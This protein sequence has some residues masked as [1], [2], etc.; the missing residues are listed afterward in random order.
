MSARSL[1]VRGIEAATRLRGGAGRL[2]VLTYHRVLPAPD[3]MYP[4]APDA[5]AFRRAMETL[6]EDFRVLPLAEA[7]RLQAAG[8]LPARAVAVTFDDGF[9]DNAT[10]A[11][12]V[13][14]AF[15][16][17]ATFFIATGYL[18]DGYMFNNAV[19]EACRA[20]PEGTWAT[21]TAEFGDVA[22][23]P[24]P[25]RP[26]LAARMIGRLK[27]EDAGR[28]RDCAEQLLAS[29]GARQPRGL[30]MSREQVRAIAAAGMD[31][32]GHTVTHPIL[33]R[34]PDA[35]A[36]REIREGKAAL[37]ELTGA[38]V[39]LFAYPNGQPDGDY[40]ARDVALVRAA[41]FAAAVTTAWGCAD[42][43]SDRFQVPRIGAWGRDAWRFS[44]RL[45]AARAGARGRSCEPAAAGG[46]A[47]RA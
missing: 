16:V 46:G 27:Y 6:A 44:V 8:R 21:G 3:P 15:G 12:P 38:P 40:T 20:A 30:M 13:L 17:P 10:E 25:S 43:A 45:A 18:G 42:A 1:V 29:A 33:A 14:R 7:L 39:T 4:T 31:I 28:R 11:L 5:A 23:G 35:A 2:L 9:A 24:P 32:G 34:L 36:E 41:G 26:A 47:A 22:A 19:I 37:E